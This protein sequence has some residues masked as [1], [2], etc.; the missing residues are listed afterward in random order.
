MYPRKGEI[1]PD[2]LA[3]AQEAKAF[4]LR[5]LEAD[6]PHI[7]VE[8]PRPLK[9]VG[10]PEKTQQIQPYEYGE[11]WSKLTC[12]WL[13]GLPRL[14]PTNLV[15]DHKPYVSCGTSRN[16]GKKDKAG[17]SRAGGASRVRSRTF[18]GIAEA[19]ATQWSEYICKASSDPS[20]AV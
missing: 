18:P 2:R 11:P 9:I 5:F 4:F 3:L 1:D 8:N 6:S 13:K 17:F 20:G 10:L 14:V 7:C 16:K 15:E 12:L 19:M